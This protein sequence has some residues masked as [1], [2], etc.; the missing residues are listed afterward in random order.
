MWRKAINELD[1]EEL[2]EAFKRARVLVVGDVMMDEFLWGK[3]ERISPEAPVPVVAVEQSSQLLGGAA[4]VVHNV[5]ALGGRAELCGV[6]GRDPTGEEV[7]RM[8]REVGVSGRGVVMDEGRPTTVKTRVIASGQQVVRFDREDTEVMPPAVEAEVLRRVQERWEE[9]DCVLVSDYGKGVVTR[10]LM[11]FLRGEAQRDGKPLVV[12]PKEGR[13]H[14]Y[15]GVTVLTPNTREAEAAA[16]Q[17]IEDLEALRGVGRKLLGKFQ[18]EAVLIT[19]GE[20]G[21]ALFRRR[22]PMV[23]IPT[24][25]K[26]VYDVTGAGDTVAAVLA[27]CLAAGEDILRASAIANCAAGVVV[28][29]VGTAVVTPEELRE[30]VAEHQREGFSIPPSEGGRKPRRR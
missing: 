10:G 17:R 8:L 6:V 14:L 4:N 23:L 1:V 21:M 7:L 5:C 15:K 28:G 30:A 9:V 29:K 3:V 13:F 11:D 2:L 20:E 24:V 19:R 18:C 27:L 16:G 12:D 22:R 26:E 25:A